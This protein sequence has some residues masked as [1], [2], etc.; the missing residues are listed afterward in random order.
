MAVDRAAGIG[1]AL[2]GRPASE[3][4]ADALSLVFVEQYVGADEPDRKRIAQ[5][6]RAISAPGLRGEYLKAMVRC[7]Q[8]LAEAIA[9]RTGSESRDLYP[10]V[11]AA[12]ALAAARAAIE[13][14]RDSRKS[15]SLA[16]VLRRA[17][18]QVVSGGTRE[19]HAS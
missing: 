7:Q 12:A 9:C 4:L 1:A 2:A 18:Q 5:V 17:I 11:L 13:F 10:R 6:H 8:S 19:D 15:T 16:A 3:S 14:W